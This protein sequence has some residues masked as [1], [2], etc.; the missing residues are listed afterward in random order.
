MY[1]LFGLL[2]AV[3]LLWG[4]WW[5]IG[6]RG[7]ESGIRQWLEARRGENWQAEYADLAVRGFPNRFDTTITE[8]RLADPETGLAWRAPFFQILS[9]SYKPNHVIAVWPDQQL[10]ATPSQKISISAEKMQASA[11]FQPDTSLAIDRATLVLQGFALRSDADWWAEVPAGQLA[12][13]KTPARTNVYDLAFEATEM[14]PSSELR[15]M[16]GGADLAEV[17]QALR[18]EAQATF[19]RP[20]DLRAIE[21]RRPQVT[22]I[23]LKMSEA[24][25]GDLHLQAAGQ[26]TVDAAGMPEGDITLRATNWREMLQLGIESGAL[27]KGLGDTLEGALELLAGLSGNK[28]TL[29]VKL[30]FGNGRVSL[31]PVPLGPAPR[32]V[33]R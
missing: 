25:W 27:P 28:N 17:F 29:D 32:L 30:S 33:I 9:L 13:R 15:R 26:L 1:R 8:V 11:V 10:L 31:G 16:L 14:R 2:V 4:G 19:D 3:A 20:W 7:M 22:D 24:L 5:V 21:E 18:I 12:I 23:D 6:A